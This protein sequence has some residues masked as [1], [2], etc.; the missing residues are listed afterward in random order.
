MEEQELFVSFK[1]ES[2]HFRINDLW[3][4]GHH[5]WSADSYVHQSRAIKHLKTMEE[6]I[7]LWK[8]FVSLFEWNPSYINVKESLVRI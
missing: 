7:Q 4:W 1:D 3:L 2:L 5:H 6:L 8:K